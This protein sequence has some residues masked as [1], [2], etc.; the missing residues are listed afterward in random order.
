M[1]TQILIEVARG[2]Q[3][4]PVA[5]LRGV[6]DSVEEDIG[7]KLLADLYDNVLAPNERRMLQALAMYRNAIPHD[8]IDWLEQR[9]P[10]TN[11]WDGLDRRCLL[12]S[13]A[14]QER[15]FVHG[16]VAGW[17]RHRLGYPDASEE[18]GAGDIPVGV[19]LAN[20]HLLEKLHS[21][22]ADC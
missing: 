17:L 1:A 14:D 19:A 15:F 12:A 3:I 18:T 13:E 7:G 16:F 22:I 10:A 4:S 21:V 2:R 6:L 8:H 11:G 5:A 9:L 20:R